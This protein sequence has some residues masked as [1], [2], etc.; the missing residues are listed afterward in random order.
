MVLVK[1]ENP[2]LNS[3]FCEIILSDGSICKVDPLLFSVLSRWRWSVHYSFCRKY[4]IRKYRKDGR[5]FYVLMHRCIAETPV[6]M[7]CHHING[8]SLDNR[9]DNLQNMSDFDHLKRHS[10]R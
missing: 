8:D 9:N 5:Q 10:Y 1:A 2:V 4:A 6:G 7:V 3:P